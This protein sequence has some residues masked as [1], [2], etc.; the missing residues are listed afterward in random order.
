[1][2]HHL[3]ITFKASAFPYGDRLEADD[4]IEDLL[5]IEGLGNVT[6]G[7][8]G[9]GSV[10]IDIEVNDLVKALRILKIYLTDKGIITTT[11]VFQLT[12]EIKQLI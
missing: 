2:N 12:P 11:R 1:M 9:A 7:G 5:L 4:E 8:S 3:S 6:G 10:D